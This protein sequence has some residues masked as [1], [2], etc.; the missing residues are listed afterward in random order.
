MSRRERAIEGVLWVLAVVLALAGRDPSH[1]LSHGYDPAERDADGLRVVTWNIGAGD[2]SS[3]AMSDV[4]HVAAT[5]RALDGDIVFL[6]EVS[7]SE[8]LQAIL[9][10]LGSG[11]RGELARGRGRRVAGIMRRSS[12]VSTLTRSID[13]GASRQSLLIE[14]RRAARS[15]VR[16]VGVHADALSS[17][18]RNRQ[19]GGSLDYLLKHGGN[20]PGVL[21]G[22]L[23]ID[24][25]LD[26]RRDMFS[27]NAHLD[28]ES[29]NYI[30][31]ELFDVGIDR[32][33]TAEPDRRLD[34]IFINARLA[35]RG[36]G[37]VR[38]RRIG[39]MDHDPLVADLEWMGR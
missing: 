26:K 3:L 23:N 30:T 8:Q 33:S 28:V 9:E 6:Q 10:G 15:P 4:D 25:D 22:D 29:Y 2:G 36:A 7:H 27:D 19:L 17:T 37:P 16:A 1:D 31:Q 13:V 38:G 14:Y 5:L 12:N 35:V 20:D 24:L 39:G 18:E 11:W 21:A 34:Y 32:G